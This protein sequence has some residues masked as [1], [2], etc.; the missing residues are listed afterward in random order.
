ME[1]ATFGPATKEIFRIFLLNH[2]LRSYSYVL[3]IR[4]YLLVVAKI[5]LVV[6]CER[7]AK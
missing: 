2:V 1:L 4:Q 5:H 6:H 7:R 3:R